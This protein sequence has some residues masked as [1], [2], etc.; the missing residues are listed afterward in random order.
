MKMKGKLVLKGIINEINIEKC[1]QFG[2]DGIIG[3]VTVMY[4]K[5]I[6][7]GIIFV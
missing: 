1:V 6:Y 2:I 5:G 4:C 7:S 3:G